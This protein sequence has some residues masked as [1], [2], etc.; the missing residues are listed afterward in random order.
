MPSSSNYARY[1]N[2]AQIINALRPEVPTYCLAPHQVT[3]NAKSMV[4]LFPGEVAYAVKCN[5]H[6][7]MLEALVAGG[8]S[9][10]DVASV[11]EMDL[12]RAARPDAALHFMHPIKTEE[13]IRQ[14]SADHAVRSFAVDHQDEMVKVLDAVSCPVEELTL[15]VRL[16]TEGGD[17]AATYDLSA[18][19][20][21]QPDRAVALL[22]DIERAGAKAGLC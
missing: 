2:A 4:S 9:S 15:M 5:G 7:V 17:Q 19:F 12:A 6:P 22:Q 16:S 8:I 14:A 3:A 11:P 1:R 13:A 18:K 10:F 21:A 20:G